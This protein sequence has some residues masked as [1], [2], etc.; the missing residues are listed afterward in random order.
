MKQKSYKAIITILDPEE[1]TMD[2][3]EY[4]LDIKGGSLNDIE[5]SVSNFRNGLL[6]N[7]GRVFWIMNRKSILKKSPQR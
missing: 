3:K 6:P 2:E 7:V 4:E 1:N 5:A